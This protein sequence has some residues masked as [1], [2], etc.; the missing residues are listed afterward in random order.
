MSD[1]KQF[2][3]DLDASDLKAL[4]FESLQALHK[5][6]GLEVQVRSTRAVIDEILSEVGREG[7]GPV[8]EFT[9]GFDRTS[10]GFDR[11]YNR[12]IPTLT[13]LGDELINPAVDLG[14]LKRQLDRPGG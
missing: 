13:K 3:V 1:E 8:A 5:K 12:D 9:R 10:P 4:T 11:Y 14:G 6:H 2:V 7:L